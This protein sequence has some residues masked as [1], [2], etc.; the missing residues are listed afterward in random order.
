MWGVPHHCPDKRLASI[1]HTGD[2]CAEAR[3]VACDGWSSDFDQV[4]ISQVFA[5]LRSEQ[6]REIRIPKPH[7]KRL[8]PEAS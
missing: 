2:G 8:R 7:F 5:R 6:R 1:L 4:G 3:H